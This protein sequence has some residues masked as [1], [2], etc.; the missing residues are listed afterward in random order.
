MNLLQRL[1][2]TVIALGEYILER[3]GRAVFGPSIYTEEN[4][5]GKVAVVTGANVGIG[6][7]VATQ[8]AGRGATV[9]LACRN[10]AEGRKA[11]E[12]I[13]RRSKALPGQVVS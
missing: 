7:E 12:D 5:E 3:L 4:I 1:I 2:I 10:L 13:S 11:Q 6:K 9:V 8:L